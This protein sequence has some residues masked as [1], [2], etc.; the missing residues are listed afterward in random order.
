MIAQGNMRLGQV[1]NH[2]GS[3]FKSVNPHRLV[4]MRGKMDLSSVKP[5]Q[6]MVLD[7][8]IPREDFRFSQ[9]MTK[10]GRI[11]LKERLMKFFATNFVAFTY[12]DV[13]KQWKPIE[14]AK[15]VEQKY[16]MLV[17]EAER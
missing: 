13:M 14:F 9:V 12:R 3:V 4:Q 2:G 1:M 5:V 16:A 15:E 17:K 7:K 10:D 8:W 6:M 11:Y